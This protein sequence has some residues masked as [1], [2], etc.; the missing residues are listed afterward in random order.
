MTVALCSIFCGLCLGSLLYRS[1]KYNAERNALATQLKDAQ[2]RCT[3]IATQK[4]EL[5]GKLSA[6]EI[7][8]LQKNQEF[9]K[10]LEHFQQISAEKITLETTRSEI[11]RHREQLKL[12][13]T[14][15]SQEILEAKKQKF[16][17]ETQKEIGHLIAD[18][19]KEF[20][21]FK[22]EIFSPE[23]KSRTELSTHL[24]SLLD[25][26]Q[27]MH[28]E[29]ENLT[30]ALRNNA[31]TQ[32]DWGEV[33]LENLL[34]Q[35]GLSEENGDYVKQG[36]GLELKTDSGAAKPDF[37]IKLPRNQW[38][39]IDAK[40]SLSAYE[41]MVNGTDPQDRERSLQQHIASIQKHI[42]EVAKYHQINNTIDICPFLLLFLPI[43]SAYASAIS[44]PAA[45]KKDIAEYAR[46]KNV[47]IVYPS[48]LF[49]TLRLIQAIWQVEKQNLNAQEIADRGG[50]L[51]DKFCGLLDELRELYKLFGKVHE[52][53]GDKIIPKISGRGG[54]LTQCD[55][56][57]KLGA[58]NK[59]LIKKE[60]LLEQ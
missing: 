21:T 6:I 25:N 7:Q 52:Q 20:S 4:A 51:Y 45:Q 3:E 58:K 14:A 48:T 46:Q 32:G 47:I 16:S 50:K 28:S 19:Q 26:V 55:D 18:L 29:A 34:E 22:N 57:Q 41:R 31:K 12:E 60:N 27:K 42:D 33:Q 56:L 40:V 53:F 10:L 38:I 9:N 1:S 30:N 39:L 17:E 5:Q 15:L 35:A 44:N 24:K 36:K 8:F 49:L 59:K 2:N 43:E 37:L 11:L 13:L 54:L 23:T